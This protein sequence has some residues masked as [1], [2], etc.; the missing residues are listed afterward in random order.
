MLTSFMLQVKQMSQVKY[1]DTYTMLA[2]AFLW[3]H[4]YIMLSLS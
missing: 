2:A 4:T 3:S 1:A